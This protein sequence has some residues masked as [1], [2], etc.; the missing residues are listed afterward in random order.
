MSIGITKL[1]TS[2]LRPEI[3]VPISTPSATV[4]AV[5]FLR[6]YAA[7]AGTTTI[8]AAAA[9][10]FQPGREATFSAFAMV[11]QPLDVNLPVGSGSVDARLYVP[12]N[13]PTPSAA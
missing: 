3:A 6:K 11:P 1:L 9:P 10:R 13:P 4:F 7:P 8:P 12:P 2:I 5:R